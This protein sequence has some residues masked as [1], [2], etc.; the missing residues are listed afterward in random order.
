[1]Y[2][3]K[4]PPAQNCVESREILLKKNDDMKIIKLQKNIKEY[5]VIAESGEN[6]SVSLI[7]ITKEGQRSEE[8]EPLTFL[9]DGGNTLAKPAK[10]TIGSMEKVSNV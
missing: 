1:M 5:R 8:S 7:D 6:V 10:P 2:L 9:V 3:V 4:L